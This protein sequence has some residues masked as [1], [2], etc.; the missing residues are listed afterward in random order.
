MVY[1]L[2]ASLLL[3]AVMTLG[4]FAWAAFRIQHR[5]AFGLIHGA[6]MC[7]CVGLAIGIRA[8]KP[9]AAAIAGPVIGV[10]AASVFYALARPLGWSAMFPAW[11]LLWIL[12]AVLQQK[13]ETKDRRGPALIRGIA[14]ALLSGTTFYLISGIWTRDSHEDPNL[15]AHFAAW[16]VAFLPGFAALFWRRPSGQG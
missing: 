5:V 16:S 4:D 9:L 8:R 3:A 11:M 10:I 1:A 13:L 14:A 6:V 12:F 15:A 2:M 7:L